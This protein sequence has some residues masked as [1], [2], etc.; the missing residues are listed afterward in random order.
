MT[1]DRPYRQALTHHEAMEE[2]KK[3]SGRQ[4]DPDLVPVFVAAVE[5]RQS[6]LEHND[7]TPM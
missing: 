4:F 7:G 5:T 6:S 2:I 3:C 1:N